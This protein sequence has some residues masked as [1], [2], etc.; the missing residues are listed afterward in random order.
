MV[1]DVADDFQVR[2]VILHIHLEFVP[3]HREQF[4][5][6]LGSQLAV[7]KDAIARNQADNS[8]LDKRQFFPGQI[9]E[10]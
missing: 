4:L 5:V 9:A 3:E 2:R 10:A 6:D 7:P 1:K 8:L